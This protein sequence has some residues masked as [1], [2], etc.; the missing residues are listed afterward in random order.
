MEALAVAGPVRVLLLDRQNVLEV[1][2]LGR[3]NCS[4]GQCQRRCCVCR[5]IFDGMCTL[6]TLNRS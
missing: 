6:P 5:C 2:Y 4:L 3:T 1:A